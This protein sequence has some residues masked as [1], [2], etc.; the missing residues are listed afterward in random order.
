M[1]R[2][3]FLYH[4]FN[5]NL[6]K[7]KKSIALNKTLLDPWKAAFNIS[8]S[9]LLFSTTPPEALN[10]KRFLAAR[11]PNYNQRKCILLATDIANMLTQ[12]EF[13]K[14]SGQGCIQ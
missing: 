5:T 6:L 10:H 12:L 2:K 9:A 8:W 1:I 4:H 14:K 3:N 13:N 11:T 7:I